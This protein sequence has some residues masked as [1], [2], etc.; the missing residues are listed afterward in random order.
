MYLSVFAVE[1]GAG[2]LIPWEIPGKQLFWY[3]FVT[4]TV[5]VTVSSVLI[6]VL[7]RVLIRRF[8]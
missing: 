2:L 4:A 5:C 6:S 7:I 1:T 8:V 3:C